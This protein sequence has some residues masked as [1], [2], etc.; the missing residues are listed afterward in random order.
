MKFYLFLVNL[1]NASSVKSMIS[2]AI[3][4]AN[5]VWGTKLGLKTAEPGELASFQ[6]EGPGIQEP[7]GRGQ[8][9]LVPATVLY[10]GLSMS[11]CWV[12]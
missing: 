8:S 2:S 6:T 12:D 1:Y 5:S 10:T 3:F 7:G 9:S 4:L 11:V